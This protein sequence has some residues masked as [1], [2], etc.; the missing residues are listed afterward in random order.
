MYDVFQT[1]ISPKALEVFANGTR[2]FKS[3]MEFY[4]LNLALQTGQKLDCTPKNDTLSKGKTKNLNHCKHSTLSNLTF[5]SNVGRL[6]A[7]S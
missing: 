4:V 3:F 1:K 7:K 2:H 5:F 6:P